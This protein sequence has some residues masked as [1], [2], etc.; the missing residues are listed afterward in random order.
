[1]KRL[2]AAVALIV[3]TATLATAPALSASA[4]PRTESAVQPRAIKYC[5]T[6]IEKIHPGQAASR[7]ISRICSDRHSPGSVLPLGVTARGLA[8]KRETL[9]VMFFQNSG[10]RGTPNSIYGGS[11]PCDVAGYGFQDLTVS[12]ADVGGITSYLLFNSCRFASYWTG[13]DFTGSKRSGYDGDN[14]NVGVP[15]NDHLLSMRTW[16]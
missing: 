6:E 11:G 5:Y 12:N 2:V 1:M 10:Y 13:T 4:A 15:W 16:S 14:T 9:L 8:S 7:V 3:G